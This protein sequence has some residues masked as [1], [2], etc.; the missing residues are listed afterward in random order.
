[1][2]QQIKIQCDQL[3]SK[4]DT[5]AAER[6]EL[7]VKI[8]NYIQSK[9]ANNEPINLVY[10]CTHNSR[11]SHF[12]QVWA[13]VAANYYAIPNV[14][15]YSGGTEATAFNPNA[16]NALKTAGFEISAYSTDA[17]P[18][19]IV[20]F[21]DNE[22]TTCFSKVYDNEVNPKS[23]FAAIMTCSDAEENCPFI[24][25]VDLRIG[26]T[27]DDPKAFDGTTLQD[28]KYL[29]RSNQI[30]LEC[31]YVF[32]LI[33]PSTCSGESSSGALIHNS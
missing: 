8:S 1:V 14:S 33:N 30:A 20:R 18:T 5:I 7:L 2:Y 4:F 15:T 31:L 10:V 19:Y 11:R 26:T 16:I 32:S 17:N 22:S 29:E 25:G 28:E 13:A 12:G 6:K 3:V 21:G 24:P 27:Y 23:N 9:I